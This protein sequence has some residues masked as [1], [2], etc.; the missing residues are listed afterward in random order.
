[1][2]RILSPVLKESQSTLPTPALPS[3]LHNGHLEKLISVLQMPT[4][5]INCYG[6]QFSVHSFLARPGS[7][8]SADA[9]ILSR[10][11]GWRSYRCENTWIWGNPEFVIKILVHAGEWSKPD[12]LQEK[13]S[14]IVGIQNVLFLLDLLSEKVMCILKFVFIFLC[15]Y[16][17]S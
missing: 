2:P 4:M 6:R 1:M 5:I 15:V 12:G 14:T 17:V 11:S 13:Y 7:S 3:R 8:Y 16:L 10:D 9:Q